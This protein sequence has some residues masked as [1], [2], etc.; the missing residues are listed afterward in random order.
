MAKTYAIS[1]KL[2][3]EDRRKL[4]TLMESTER[5]A[6]NLFRRMLHS[7]EIVPDLRLPVDHQANGGAQ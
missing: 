4:E 2:D 7:V 1:V 5:S 6:G 3:D